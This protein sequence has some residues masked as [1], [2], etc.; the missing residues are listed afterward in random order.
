M[1]EYRL[2]WFVPHSKTKYDLH[3]Y[4][5]DNIDDLEWIKEAIIA[6]GGKAKIIERTER[7]L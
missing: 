4:R 1:S 7:V 6:H 5:G 3:D 2:E